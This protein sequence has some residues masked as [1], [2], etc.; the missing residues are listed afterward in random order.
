VKVHPAAGVFTTLV[1]T[2]ARGVNVDEI[3]A[4][5][6]LALDTP[7]VG[8]MSIQPVFGSGRTTGVDPNARLT[9]TGVL[10]DLVAQPADG[11]PTVT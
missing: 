6:D 8:G 7:F 9:H 3:G 4:V 2:A 5:I 11:S 1:M 10:R